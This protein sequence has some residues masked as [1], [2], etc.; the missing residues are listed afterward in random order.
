MNASEVKELKN[1][2][3]PE[4]IKMRSEHREKLR[5]MRLDLAAGKVKN[6]AALRELKKDIARI[7]TVLSAQRLQKTS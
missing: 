3:A 6:E 1:K 5:G 4:L 7:E 2:P